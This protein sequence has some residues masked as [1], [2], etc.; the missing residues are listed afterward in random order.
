MMSCISSLLVFSIAWSTCPLF[1]PSVSPG[2]DS[3]GLHFLGFLT[4][5]LL[6]SVRSGGLSGN[7]GWGTEA[8]FAT[9]LCFRAAPGSCVA[10]CDHT[11]AKL[12]HFSSAN[13][14]WAHTISS[15]PSLLHSW[16][17]S[18]SL[19]L[20]V[21]GYSTSEQFFKRL[22]VEWDLVPAIGNA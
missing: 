2:T 13:P 4:G 8:F 10:P 15:Y 14:H 9:C 16:S 21:P 18:G 1:C 5:I 17:G 20:L 22:H 6:S 19:L 3:Y 11:P 7:G 12:L